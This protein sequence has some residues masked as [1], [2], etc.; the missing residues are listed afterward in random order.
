MSMGQLALR[1]TV[2]DIGPCDAPSR[3]TLLN[4]SVGLVEDIRW[5]GDPGRSGAD[6]FSPEFQVALPYRGLFVWH[7]GS[8]EVVGDAN[9]VL[10]VTGG[11]RYRMSH[12]ISGGYA[13]LIITLAECI[14]SELSHSRRGALASHALFRRRSRRLNPS[15]QSF[16]A[17][18]L[19]WASEPSKVDTLAAD[20]L[21]LSLLRLA[22]D[23]EA[24][25]ARP[26][27]STQRLIRRTKA[28]LEAELAQPI[29]LAD[30]SRFVGASPAY[31]THVFRS[32]EG[33]PL[34][35]Y[36]TQL[37]LARALVELPQADD[38]TKLALDVGFSSHSHFSASFHRAYGTTPSQFREMSRSRLPPAFM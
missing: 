22:L 21:A 38:L 30:I 20:E 2:E 17:R 35:Q 24:A 25:V 34:H 33:V 23:D 26:G 31:L 32:I 29:R 3:T 14:V 4:L 27:R 12:P 8:D 16:R 5:A 10:F 15:L 36:L 7:V 1:Q 11:E 13:E 6:D 9:Q 18:F 37:R 19:S 28:F